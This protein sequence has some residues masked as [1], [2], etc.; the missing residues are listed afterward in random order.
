MIKKIRQLNSA[1]PGMLF[2]IFVAGVI[3]EMIFIW[4]VKDKAGFTLGLFIGVILAV[5]MALHMAYTLDAAINLG[6]GGAIKVM[7]KH[8]LLRYG[9]V[10]LVCGVVMVTKIA[11]PLAVF[12]GIMTLKVAAYFEPFTHKLFRR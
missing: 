12:L 2:V 11:N 7:Q 6:E 10:V 8:N 3:L 1:L 5:V 4:F 9:V